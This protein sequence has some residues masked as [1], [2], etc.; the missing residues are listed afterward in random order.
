[1]ASTVKQLIS[2]YI[3][4][5]KEQS[6]SRRKLYL[7]SIQSNFE[8][9]AEDIA[10][11]FDVDVDDV[12]GN[13][14]ESILTSDKKHPSP[15]A[16][17]NSG[18][19]KNL[20]KEYYYYLWDY[21]V[22][23]K[24]KFS[25]DFKENTVKQPEPQKPTPGVVKSRKIRS[26]KPNQF[27]KE[28]IDPYILRALGLDDIRDFT[29]EEYRLFLKEFLI[30]AN[31][32]NN[33]ATSEV[34]PIS[35]EFK[36]VKDKTGPF[37]FVKK[38]KVD[39][40][41]SNIKIK[42]IL[43]P[44]KGSKKLLKPSTFDGEDEL[45][46]ILT[47]LGSINT[48]F[49]DSIKKG[50]KETRK[51]R[52]EEEKKNR[53]KRE[54]GLELG[55][56]LKKLV[57]F[58]T[59]LKPFESV[60][61]AIKRFIFF[62]VLG[63][64]FNSLIKW[65]ND[66]VNA[67]KVE[68]L[69]RFVKDWWPAILAAVVLFLTPLGGFILSTL[70]IV[71]GLTTW[72]IKLVPRML[73]AIGGLKTLVGKLAKSKLV[74]GAGKLLRSPLGKAGLV[75]GAV[76]G[77]SYLANE[78]T[79]QNK[80]A[81]VQTE[82]A[83]KVQSG[84]ALPVPGVGN[85]GN[86]QA[87]PYGMVQG[88]ASGGVL[89]D[90]YGGVE[91]DTGVSV[92]GAG[93]DTQLIVAKPGEV[94]LTHKDQENIH[95]KTGFDVAEYVGK[96]PIKKVDSSKI[97]PRG[98]GTIAS[99]LGSNTIRG[100][101]WG[102]I[103]GGIRERLTG[104]NNPLSG[105]FGGQSPKP[106]TSKPSIQRPQPPI[107][108]IF[109]GTSKPQTSKPSVQRSKPST[110]G[111]FGGTS[112]PQISKPSVQR[113]QPT[114]KPS[115]QKSQLTNKSPSQGIFGGL[116]NI[117]NPFSG[118]FGGDKS[119]P[120]MPGSIGGRAAGAATFNPAGRL[121]SENKLLLDVLGNY[122]GLRLDAYPDANYGWGLPT[123]GF[124]ATKIDGRPVKRGDKITKEKAFEMKNKDVIEHTQRARK[125]I[126]NNLDKLPPHVRVP[127][128]S[129]IFNYGSYDDETV[130]LIKQG[131]KTKNY[132]PL[133]EYIK[134]VLG[135]HNGGV[136][137]WRREDEANIIKTGV[138]KRLGGVSIPQK[139]NSDMIKPPSMSSTGTSQLLRNNSNQS[140]IKP[141]NSSNTGS[142]VSTL[143]PIVGGGESPIASNSVGGSIDFMFSS[144]PN[145]ALTD[146]QRILETYGVMVG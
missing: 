101:Q 48:I 49:K 42:G 123:I 33:R 135:E 130:K 21:Y 22:N 115:V 139:L 57:V 137:R 8:L 13:V 2:Q 138:S 90:G 39:S 143:P 61:D 131:V 111:V 15:K 5:I 36:R 105:M 59:L 53:T 4:P 18:D 9:M 80:A 110:Q 67:K 20:T 88:V 16:E 38:K 69:N 142:K 72:I 63:K 98:G 93:P 30:T 79:G 117:P 26:K 77:T 100:Y 3:T 103:V 25:G 51:N 94:V 40:K 95:S 133:A 134:T 65:F 75:V 35:N 129:L 45:S 66:P 81:K 132:S 64:I 145:S 91:S 31:R 76:A 140:N 44:A 122:E 114:S 96:R 28:S 102:G 89:E 34:E 68:T 14:I 74:R 82:N 52:I 46:K 146:R 118:L 113:P 86:I 128:L 106:K 124:G 97:E 56:K 71:K 58:K 47:T 126:G 92:T 37:E 55:N 84:K 85:V 119:K 17:V 7:E 73:K 108:N 112:K 141:Y 78:I 87:T 50:T 27:V 1:M 104:F 6:A 19:N 24:D 70:K 109:G 107:M 62:T 144:I 11:K 120:R 125:Q 121:E 116:Q 12:V 41:T 136:N 99:A 60:L 23:D 54:D 32:N 83:A 29:Y 127:L 10:K 43:R